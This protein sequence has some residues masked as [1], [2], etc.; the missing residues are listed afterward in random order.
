MSKPAQQQIDACS[1]CNSETIDESIED[2]AGVCIYCGFVVH[3]PADTTTP[4]WIQSPEEGEEQTREDWLTVCRVRNSTEQQLARAFAALEDIGKSLY[5]DADLR[6]EA[7]AVYCDAF[8][9]GTTDGRDTNCVIAACARLASLSASQPI[10]PGRL[11]ELSAVDP[12]KYRLSQAALQDDLGLNP[13]PPTPEDY[14]QFLA[15][16]LDLDRPVLDVTESTLQQIGG[17][18]PLVGKD[19]VGITAAAVYLAAENKTQSEVADAGGISTETIRQR[20]NEL[21]S[22]VSDD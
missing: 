22:L 12:R 11:S 19:P 17:H 9:A 18:S 15:G 6:Q 1:I 10:P 13:V 14:V 3:D 8:V 16:E 21:R 4:E 7:A 20:V 5:L 2:F